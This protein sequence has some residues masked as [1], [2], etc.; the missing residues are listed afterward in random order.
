ML[1]NSLPIY[2]LNRDN[3]LISIEAKEDWIIYD[4][5]YRYPS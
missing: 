4:K 2:K 5:I 3:Q 1:V